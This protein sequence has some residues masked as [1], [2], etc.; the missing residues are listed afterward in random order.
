MI[1]AEQIAAIVTGGP[2]WWQRTDKTIY[3]TAERTPESSDDV[4]LLSA[5]ESWKA[6]W[7]NDWQKAADQINAAIARTEKEES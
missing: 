3:A 1:T 4:Y 5:S 2:F 7:D 6:Q